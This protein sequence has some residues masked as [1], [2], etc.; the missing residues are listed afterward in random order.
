M[1]SSRLCFL[2]MPASW[3]TSDIEVSQLPRCPIA[4]FTLSSAWA[5]D[6]LINVTAASAQA[7]V[8]FLIVIL[9]EYLAGYL[10]GCGCLGTRLSGASLPPPRLRQLAVL[11]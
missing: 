6:T 4:S 7:R 8:T 9:P 2:K 3:P 11:G 1:S 5:A 10:A